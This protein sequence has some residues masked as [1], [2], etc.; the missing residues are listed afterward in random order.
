MINQTQC[1]SIRLR[2]L[3]LALILFLLSP[4]WLGAAR[5]KELA[6]INGVRDNQLVGYGLG[7]IL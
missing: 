7:D 5:I 3:V 2:C 6:D 1:G 4:S